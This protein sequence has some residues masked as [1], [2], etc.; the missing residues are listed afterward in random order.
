VCIFASAGARGWAVAGLAGLKTTA[1]A[2][3]YRCPKQL[4]V[5][6]AW[7]I[8]SAYLFYIPGGVGGTA[9]ATSALG[10]GILQYGYQIAMEAP[11]LAA[12]FHADLS[13]AG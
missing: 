6:T 12:S 9:A 10:G 3:D 2:L 11:G 5:D 8:G 13:G 4:A 1:S 7:N